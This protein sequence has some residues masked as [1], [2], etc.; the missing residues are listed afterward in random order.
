[1]KIKV[2]ER[3]CCSGGKLQSI[4]EET[5]TELGIEADIEIINDMEGMMALGIIRTPALLIDDKVVL[6]GRIPK[7]DEM[8]SLLQK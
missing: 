3:S 7:K 5:I 4:T 2:V 8:K 6:Q 1:M